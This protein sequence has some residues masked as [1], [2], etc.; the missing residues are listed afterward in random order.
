M[1]QPSEQTSRAESQITGTAI[2][3]PLPTHLVTRSAVPH[4]D[5]VTFAII[6]PNTLCI[7]NQPEQFS[8][9]KP[10]LRKD[11][12]CSTGNFAQKTVKF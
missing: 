1:H 5:L 8:M 4:S 12:R 10:L 11:I 9:S 2:R 7:R 6:R 3:V